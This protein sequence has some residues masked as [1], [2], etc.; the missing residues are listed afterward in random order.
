M[1]IHL[2]RSPTSRRASETTLADKP[3]EAKT[4]NERLVSHLLAVEII[5]LHSQ[6]AH[7]RLDPPP[8]PQTAIH[9]HRLALCTL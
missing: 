5:V 9:T 2:K 6:V 7:T 8:P 1:K 4:L 3:M